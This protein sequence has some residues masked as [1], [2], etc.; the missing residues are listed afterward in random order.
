[1]SDISKPEEDGI[2]RQPGE[3]DESWNKRAYDFAYNWKRPLRS[4]EEQK[5]FEE[6]MAAKKVIADNMVK[7]LFTPDESE[8]MNTALLAH[9][10]DKAE[11]AVIKAWSEKFMQ[12]AKRNNRN[13]D[14]AA[15]TVKFI[16]INARNMR[17]LKEH[18][19]RIKENKVRVRDPQ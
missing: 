12:C 11:K 19:K 9:E 18:Q 16:A 5:A 10:I 4:A 17:F 8:E 3:T 6:D 13:L 2:S 14:E 1:M 7:K 15:S